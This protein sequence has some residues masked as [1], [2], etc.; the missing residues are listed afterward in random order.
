MIKEFRNEKSETRNGES[1]FT[2]IELL[3][4][5]SIIGIL[6]ALTV[7]NFQQARE[8]ARDVQRKSEMKQL[9][10][11]LELYKDDQIPQR[12]P[13]TGQLGSLV[14]TYLKVLPVDPLMKAGLGWVDY[15][16]TIGATN[17]Q[18]TLG[19][20]LENETDKD[21]TGATP[22]PGYTTGKLYVVTE[23]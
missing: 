21:A 12:Y 13:S 7:F 10:N 11:A 6:V 15:A 2:L 18:Y 16:Y 4:V 9:Q 20:C 1:G 22:C 3:V 17:L 23:P 5:I 14:P 8:R 19:A